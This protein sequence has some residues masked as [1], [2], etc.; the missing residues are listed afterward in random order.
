MYKTIDRFLACL[1]TGGILT[2]IELVFGRVD[3]S[4]IF[5]AI[6]ITKPATMQITGARIQ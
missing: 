2:M 3:Y 6:N 4:L 1:T 5:L